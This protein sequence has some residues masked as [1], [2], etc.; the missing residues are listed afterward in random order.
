MSQKEQEI[1][2][3]AWILRILKNWYWFVLSCAICGALGAYKY[4]TTTKEYKVDASIMLREDEEAFP[5]FEMVTM[6]A[7]LVA[8]LVKNPPAMWEPWV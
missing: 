8:Q 4:V 5:T 1:D 6:W 2:I 7:F 3:R